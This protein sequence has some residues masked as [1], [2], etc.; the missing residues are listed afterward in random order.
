MVQLEGNVGHLAVDPIS[1]RVVDRIVVGDDEQQPRIDERF[2]GRVRSTD[3]TR[4]EYIQDLDRI[5]AHSADVGRNAERCRYLRRDRHQGVVLQDDVLLREVAHPLDHV[6]ARTEVDAARISDRHPQSV[7]AGL[8]DGD[9]VFLAGPPAREHVLAHAEREVHRLTLRVDDVMRDGRLS[10]DRE[11][12]AGLECGAPAHR[13]VDAGVDGRRRVGLLAV[14]H[15][16]RGVA[17]EIRVGVGRVVTATSG[18]QARETE[19]GE[20]EEVH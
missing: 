17:L 13:R 19:N 2:R 7:E 18:D 6:R 15:G 12:V 3:E 14:D 5:A 11:Q 16:G 10:A 4:P 8:A 9:H 20:A 1:I